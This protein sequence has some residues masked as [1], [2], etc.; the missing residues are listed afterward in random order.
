MTLQGPSKTAIACARARACHMLVDDKPWIYEDRTAAALVDLEQQIVDGYDLEEPKKRIFSE[1]RS[2]FLIR[3]RYGEDMLADAVKDGATQYVVLGAGLNTFAYNG[4]DTSRIV[5]TFEVDH[6]ATQTWKKSRLDELGLL[7]QAKVV[8]VPVDFASQ[9]VGDQLLAHGFD[10]KS[11]AVFTCT[12]VCQYID[13]SAIN[14]TL[15]EIL[16]VACTGSRLSMEIIFPL[17]LL[18]AKDQND[19]EFFKQRSA[20]LGEPWINA[21]DPDE[22]TERL[23]RLGFDEVELLLHD[24]A[25]ER[26]IGDR[27]DGLK[28]NNYAAMI[29]ARVL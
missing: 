16:R 14:A 1:T 6:P 9:S 3:E 8:Y 24:D 27:S 26:Y 11:P 28:V 15:V 4:S 22:F 7:D 13:D 21:Q 19:L 29:K 20:E 2:I 12:G 5:T 18:S 17:H 10:S 23:R 25:H